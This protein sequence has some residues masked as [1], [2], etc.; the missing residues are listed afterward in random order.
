MEQKLVWQV[1]AF[2]DFDIHHTGEGPEEG[3][4]Y[5]AFD[6]YYSTREAAHAMYSR[7]ERELG[8]R[9]GMHW[10]LRHHVVDTEW[11]TTNFDELREILGAK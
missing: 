10:H 1:I 5:V 4:M 9:Y 3:E 7:G 2:A 8:V 11:D 6:H